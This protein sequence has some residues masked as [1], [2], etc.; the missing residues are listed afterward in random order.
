MRGSTQNA[1]R[2]PFLPCFIFSFCGG[3]KAGIEAVVLC[4]FGIGPG[5]FRTHPLGFRVQAGTSSRYLDH[6]CLLHRLAL[7]KVSDDR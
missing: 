6:K 5:G 3:P 7:K 2:M 4:H 1:W